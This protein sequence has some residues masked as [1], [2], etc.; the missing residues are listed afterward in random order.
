GTKYLEWKPERWLSPLPST[1]TEAR[2]P[3]VYSNLVTFL[4][5]GRGCIGFKFS[6]V[7]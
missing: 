3:G 2:V 7:E 1:V 5:G 6:E 4:G